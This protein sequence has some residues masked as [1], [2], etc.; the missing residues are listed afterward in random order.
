MQQVPL[1]VRLL[2]RG[3]PQVKPSHCCGSAL[4]SM[5]I[6]IRIQRFFINVDPDP[7]PNPG[8]W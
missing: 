7:D 3:C 1:L 8:F 5:R 2:G 6:R 4:V